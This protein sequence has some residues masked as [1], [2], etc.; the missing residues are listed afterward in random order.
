ME[1]GC[2]G[3]RGGSGTW[4]AGHRGCGAAA[5]GAVLTWWYTTT[6]ATDTGGYG[7]DDRDV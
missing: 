3:R 4:K 1:A 7:Y 2:W 6:I 5:E